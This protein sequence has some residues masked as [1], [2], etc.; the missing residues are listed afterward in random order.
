MRDLRRVDELIKS[1]IFK[2]LFLLYLFVF[3][4]LYMFF[5]EFFIN[6]LSSI[7]NIIFVF[8]VLKGISFFF[9]LLFFGFRFLYFIRLC[10]I[11]VLRVREF[12]LFHR[13]YSESSEVRF[14][15]LIITP[16][17]IRYNFHIIN[18]LRH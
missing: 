12:I 17:F 3:L 13:L 8:L 10:N 2:Q 16:R 7:Q 4:S 9:G 11:R 1:I 6:L 5:V 15:C 14:T 18:C